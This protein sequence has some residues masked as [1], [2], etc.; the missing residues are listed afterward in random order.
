MA[1][2]LC[3]LDELPDGGSRGFD[4]RR[5]G[6]DTLLVV[7][8]GRQLFA[9]ADAC[10][11]HGTPMAWRK[12]AYL[13]AAGDRIV[14]AAHG[15]LFEID[16]GLCVQGPCLGDSLAPIPLITHE[17]GEVHLDDPAFEETHP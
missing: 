7:R 2:R 11:H 5:G 10:P 17:D 1:M 12:D 15:A 3:H 6:Q 14:C 4:S 8:R 16:T 9:Y 13:N